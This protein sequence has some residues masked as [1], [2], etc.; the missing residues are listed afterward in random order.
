MDD[1]GGIYPLFLET[2][3]WIWQ[4][5]ISPGV[6]DAVL[7]AVPGC[8]VGSG[9]G[10]IIHDPWWLMMCLMVPRF[11]GESWGYPPSK[12]CSVSSLDSWNL[13]FCGVSFCEK[14]SGGDNLLKIHG[15]WENM[16]TPAQNKNLW[17]TGVSKGTPLLC[18]FVFLLPI[19]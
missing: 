2:S 12:L 19:I 5:L 6:F 7:I 18:R 9:A 1:L 16:L 15:N 4:K 10:W 3:T 13:E 8:G 17:A 14:F 11:L